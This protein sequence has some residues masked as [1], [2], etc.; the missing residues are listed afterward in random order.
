MVK[1]WQEDDSEIQQVITWLSTNSWPDKTPEGS[2]KLK[3]FWAQRRRIKMTNGVLTREWEALGTNKKMLLPV[4][5]RTRVPEV[6]DLIHNHPTGGHL[7][8]AK[9]LEKIQQRFYWPQ[10]REDVEDW[11]RLCDACASR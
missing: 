10:Q 11:C 5:P 1:Q 9:S 7:W 2:R 8:V 6:L 4:I 3:S